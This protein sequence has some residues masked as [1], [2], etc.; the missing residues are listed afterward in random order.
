MNLQAHSRLFPLA[1]VLLVLIALGR[2]VSTYY[3]FNQTEDEPLHLACGMEWLDHGKYHY[4]H[5]HPPL[6]RIVV[7]I[8]PYLAG[9]RSMG[10]ETMLDEGNAI[11]YSDKRY[12]RNLALARLGILPFFILACLIVWLWS[13]RLF[14]NVAALF[15][16]LLFTTLPPIL[17]HAGLATTDMAL[18][19]F[20]CGSAYAFTLWLDQPGWKQSALLGFSVAGAVLSKFSAL[21]FLPVCFLIAT[22]LYWLREQPALKGISRRI[23]GTVLAAT[24]VFIVVWAGY[25]FS[26]GPTTPDVRFE[27][28]TP[29]TIDRLVDHFSLPAP[30]F[31]NGVAEVEWHNSVGH[32]A[33]LLGE[34]RTHGWWYFFPVVFAVKTPIAFILLCIAGYCAC[35]SRTVWKRFAWQQWVPGTCAP[36]I[37]VICMPSS[38]NLGVRYI[39]GIYP[40]LAIMGGGGAVS[41]LQSR[42]KLGVI[43]A[44]ALVAWQTGASA[45]AHPDYLAYFNELAGSQPERVLSDS[46]LDWGQDLQRLSDKLKEL[47][48]KE[49]S[50]DYFGT[51]DVSQHGLPTIKLLEAYRPVTGW[52]A[53]SAYSLTV[54][55]ALIQK[56]GRMPYS[57]LAWLMSERPV[58]RV[59]KSIWLYYIPPQR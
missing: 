22:L 18:S 25:R 24:M 50:L 58:A 48:V 7:A 5:H 30:E 46:D 36:A 31:F 12:F 6:A 49:V 35:F 40:L 13:R 57:P 52:V 15:A 53:V 1:A 44:I 34:Y 51:A 42:K 32:P 26:F 10:R 38:I 29:V 45:L 41:L 21:L 9:L 20:L 23:P 4:E 33:W 19:A 16:T 47:G 54:E 56:D 11:L 28:R 8:G 37:L 59:G 14:G 43:L 39:L 3:V 2:I 17:A 55:S 27:D